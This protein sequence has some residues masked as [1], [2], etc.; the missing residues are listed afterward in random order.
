MRSCTA[1]TASAP[2]T[3]CSASRPLDY[4]DLR[5]LVDQKALQEFRRQSLNPEHPTNRGNNVNPDIYFQCK[6]GANVKA[7]IVPD[8]I[9]HYMD[10]INKLTGRDYKLF[11]YYGAPDAEEVIVVMCSA[12]EAVK[13]TVDYLN[14]HSPQGRH[15]AD[16][17]VPPFSVKHFAAAI[18]ASVKKI[19]VLDRSKGDRFGRRAGI[20]RRRDRPQSGRP[21]RHHGRRRPLRPV[22]TDTT[23][24]SSSRSTKTSRR[25][26]RRTTSP[27]ASTTTLPTPRSTTPRS[28]CRIRSDQ[29]QAV[30]SRRR[31]HGRREQER[32]LDHRLCR[33]QVRAGVFLPM[34]R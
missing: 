10:E 17:P 27:S 7:A 19:A 23:R 31:R 15:G 12:S 5:G 14:A 30:G 29:L 16:P 22:L 8:T 33:R 20:P 34:T 6:E 1:S 25:S 32:Y 11:N 2:R 13:E 9:Q 21:E 4:E 28:S 26:S 3:R 18:P 24:A